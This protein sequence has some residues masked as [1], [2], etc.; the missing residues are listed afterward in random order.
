VL[1][2]SFDGNVESVEPSIQPV[3]P[4]TALEFNYYVPEAFYRSPA[5]C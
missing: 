3:G 2:S 5:V 4:K 1:A